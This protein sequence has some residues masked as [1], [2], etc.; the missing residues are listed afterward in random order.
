MYSEM[1]IWCY[2]IKKYCMKHGKKWGVHSFQ[3][4]GQ[5]FTSSYST[6]EC[7]DTNS[8][9]NCQSQAKS[10]IFWFILTVYWTLLQ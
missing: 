3:I 9:K 8:D 5:A 10:H 6:Q 7:K 4:D 1:H 2:N